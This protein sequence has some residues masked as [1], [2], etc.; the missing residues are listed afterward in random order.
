MN[1]TTRIF[2]AF[3]VGA[4]IGCVSGILMAPKS[5]A[6]TRRKL[7]RKGERIVSDVREIV[8]DVQDKINESKDRLADMKEDF[9]KSVKAKVEEFA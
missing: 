1:N 4:T 8:E 6:T 3:I 7:K 5:G 9:V 2:T